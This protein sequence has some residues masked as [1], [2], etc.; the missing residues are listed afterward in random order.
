MQPQCSIASIL[1][2]DI[3]ADD[4]ITDACLAHGI[5]LGVLYNIKTS[6]TFWRSHRFFDVKLHGSD[7]ALVSGQIRGST[8]NDCQAVYSLIR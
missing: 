1:L 4:Q 6:E 5:S 3:S 7:I 8:A 2:S